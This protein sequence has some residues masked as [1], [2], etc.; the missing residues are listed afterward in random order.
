MTK[1]Y[2]LFSKW[3][4]RKLNTHDIFYKIVNILHAHLFTSHFIIPLSAGKCSLSPCDIIFYSHDLY[5]YISKLYLIRFCD[6]TPTH[7]YHLGHISPSLYYLPSKALARY[8]RIFTS[9][10]VNESKCRK[11]RNQKVSFRRNHS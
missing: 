2:N 11:S 8:S 7:I 9:R 4:R 1:L 3:S 6:V 10:H 5:H